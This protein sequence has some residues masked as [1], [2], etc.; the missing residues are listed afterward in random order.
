MDFVPTMSGIAPSAQDERAIAAV[1][2]A[3]GCFIDRRDFPDTAA[4]HAFLLGLS[5]QEYA[6]KQQAM[7]DFLR[8]GNGQKRS[9]A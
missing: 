9:G 5:A 6:R 3:Y 1:L 2:L 8:S 7:R 4:V